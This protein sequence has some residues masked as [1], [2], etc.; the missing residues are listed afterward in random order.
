MQLDLKD[1]GFRSVTCDSRA[2]LTKTQVCASLI[3]TSDMQPLQSG[4][5][6]T[7]LPMLSCTDAR[8]H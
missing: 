4:T 7:A 2:L 1:I 3:C 8:S 5:A 6:G